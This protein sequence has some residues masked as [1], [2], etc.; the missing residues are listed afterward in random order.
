MDG[1]VANLC[2]TDAPYNCA[3]EGGT[4][5]TIMNDKWDDSEKFYQ[6]L[7]AAFKNIYDHLTDGGAFYAIL[8]RRRSTSTTPRWTAGFITVPLAFG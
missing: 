8:T 1:A 3:Y 7:L 6:F 2:I 4:G 5:M